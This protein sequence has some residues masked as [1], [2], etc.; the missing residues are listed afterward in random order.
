MSCSDPKTP[1]SFTN[2]NQADADKQYPCQKPF[3]NADK[4][5]VTLYTTVIFFIVSAPF[6]YILVDKI[7]GRLLGFRVASSSG[8]PTLGGLFIHTVVFTLIVRA[9]MG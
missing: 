3:T 7:L 2:M 9:L 8:C 5:R 1:C 4:W 6:L